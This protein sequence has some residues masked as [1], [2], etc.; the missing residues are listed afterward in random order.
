MAAAAKAAEAVGTK[1]EA[2]GKQADTAFSKMAQ[3]A[4]T[5]KDEWTKVGTTLLAVGAV[6]AAGIGVAVKSFA[7]FSAEMA[8][9][10]T[11]AHASAADMNLLTDAA[12]SAGTAY[13]YSATQ[14]AQA[15]TELVKAGMSVKDILG[16]SLDGALTIAAAGQM[17]VADA[18]TIAV[19][20]MTQYNLK[21]SDTAHVAD[22]LAAGADK[23]LA[24]ISSLGEGMKYV[25]PVAAQ[26]G[27][28][29]DQ[30]VGVLSMFSQ[31]GIDATMAG[32]GLRGVLMSMTAP[33]ALASKA[34][35][36]Y[37]I[38]VFDAQGK[39]IGL[40][41]LAGEL[42]DKLGN[43]DE[44]TRSAALGQIFGNRQITAARILYA[45]GSQAVDQ[46][47]NS[48]N[49]AGFA[50]QQASG[51]LDSL[52]G[53]AQKMGTAF[54]TSLVDNGS[55][56]NGVL[57]SMTQEVTSVL[58]AYNKM[59]PATQGTV[60]ATGALVSVVALASGGFLVLAPRVVETRAALA[61][62]RTD[63]PKTSAALGGVAKVAGRISIALAAAAVAGAALDK[64][65]TK[66][67]TVSQYTKALLDLNGAMKPGS[68]SILKDFGAELRS[69]A[70][71]S[72]SYRIGDVVS[73][74]GK[75]WGGPTNTEF[76]V[77]RFHD[78][79]TALADLYA[80]NPSLAA[81][82]FAEVMRITGGTT[83][84]L[85]KLMPA[86]RD[87]LQGVANE[88][89]IAAS[90]QTDV[91]AAYKTTTG[92]VDDQIKSLGDLI[93]AQADAA[94]VV[95]SERDAQ[96]GL[97]Q[98]I[99]DAT[100]SLKKNG[101]TLD[102]TTQKGR[103]NQAAL[104]A[105]AKSGWDLVKAM[106]AN[107]SSQTD[108]QAQ[109]GASRDAFIN[110][111]ESMG[112]GTDAAKALADQ[113]DLI[114]TAVP[115][116]IQVDSKNAMDQISAVLD[117]LDKAGKPA[118]VTAETV[119][120]DSA[121]K[122]LTAMQTAIN[123]INGSKVRIAMGAGGSGGTT[124]A[125]G[126]FTGMGGKYEPAGIVHRGEYVIKAEQVPRIGLARLDSL[127]MRGYASGGLVG[128]SAPA[129][130]SSVSLAGATVVVRVGEREFTGYVAEVADN[131]IGQAQNR[132]TVAIRS[133]AR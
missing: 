107:G 29:V 130:P 77:Q 49:D 101:K 35:E 65:M 40:S 9:V 16:G 132:R 39:F 89:K 95:L 69:L 54:Q 24:S 100:D 81:S 94:G 2:A 105:I 62:L 36:Q 5:N 92:S 88:S 80:S 38:N 85:L 114:P 15:E 20:A 111:A 26:M 86:Y 73:N 51:K 103:D 6:V 106:Q 13:G 97:Q 109:M 102:D 52:S 1:S 84:E 30:T 131:R 93:S 120:F 44:A 87:A 83:D 74:I 47:T 63:M 68:D 64:A 60:L 31:S 8:Q 45:G 123:G 3:S 121:L 78:L 23:S 61:T 4:R 25:G 113:L 14:V 72:L 53:D 56:A 128:G 115:T 55:A 112:M 127:N 10:R 22:V 17:D 129:G 133:G 42:H 82:K 37:G 46:W 125:D 98:S 27:V 19:S 50:S 18:T 41:G 70:D 90:S 122:Y 7:D 21:A 57:R 75:L 104:D 71:P 66:D 117:L 79:G 96:R 12:K 59:S 110:A 116:K 126:G 28:S 33:S 58:E 76:N 11:L 91:S 124:F 99:A 43:L 67:V 108:I 32:T 48:V 119:G 118:V 34:M